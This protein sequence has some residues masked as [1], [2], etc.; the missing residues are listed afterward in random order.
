MRRRSFD[1]NSNYSLN[2]KYDKK[3]IKRNTLIIDDY[4]LLKIIV[5]ITIIIVIM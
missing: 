5:I 1:F 3:D 4:I 2:K